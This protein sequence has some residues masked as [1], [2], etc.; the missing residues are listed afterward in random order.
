MPG[1]LAAAPTLEALASSLRAAART[2]APLG[3]LRSLS[4]QRRLAPPIK[5]A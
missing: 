1:R 5:A 2:G 3:H 4:D